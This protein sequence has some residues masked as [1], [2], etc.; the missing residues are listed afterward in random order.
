MGLFESEPCK[1]QT[2][3]LTLYGKESDVRYYSIDLLWG[4][5][6]YQKPRFVLVEY[7]GVQGILASLQK[8]KITLQKTNTSDINQNLPTPTDNA[9]NPAG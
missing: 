9:P 1:F 6:L 4:Q 5:K 3:K 8:L 2:A 7:Q